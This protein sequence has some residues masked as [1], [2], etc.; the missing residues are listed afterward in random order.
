LTCSVKPPLPAVSTCSWSTTARK[1]TR[2]FPVSA[3]VFAGDAMEENPD[4]LA[5]EAGGLGRL[6][7]P[8]FMF[9]EGNDREVEQA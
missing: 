9:Q 2:L 1:E 3:L 7:V 5:H 8:V 6:G 4:T